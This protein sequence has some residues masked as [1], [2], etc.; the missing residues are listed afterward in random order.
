MRRLGFLQV[1]IGRC[2]IKN[3][4]N[5]GNQLGERLSE[6][7]NQYQIV[8]LQKLA[9]KR[10]ITRKIEVGHITE[11]IAVRYVKYA[12][13]I[14][15]L[16][17]GTEKQ[18]TDNGRLIKMFHEKDFFIE[19]NI[20]QQILFI[21]S[22][23][24]RDKFM[25]SSIINKISSVD[26]ISKL[27][28]YSWFAEEIIPHLMNVLYK[29]DQNELAERLKNTKQMYQGSIKEKRLGY[30]RIKHILETR[31]EN[32]ID[33]TII[34]KTPDKKYSPNQFTKLLNDAFHHIDRDSEALFKQIAK[35][36]KIEKKP[37]KSDLTKNYLKQYQMLVD[38]P[39]ESI[40]L[41]ALHLCMY[42]EGIRIHNR[43]I[44]P[45][46]IKDLEKLIHKKLYG[47]AVFLRDHNGELSH[48]NLNNKAKKKLSSGIL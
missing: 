24:E 45:S 47:D 43:L 37:S 9:N 44:L 4:M 46:M 2:V 30:D 40:F 8:C 14:G 32:L 13:E 36:F 31:L 10:K 26:T 38:S 42:I 25:F 27:E 3:E 29:V 11:K 39:I 48:I 23:A 19:E 1:L 28:L 6:W 16:T 5:S 15:Y 20:G 17:K 12:T 22:L 18:L 33:L 41:P 7:A 34:K 35:Y 21:F